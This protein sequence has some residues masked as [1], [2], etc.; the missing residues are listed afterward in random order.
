MD[1]KLS[2]ILSDY[3][4][5][6]DLGEE[7]GLYA[8]FYKAK[9]GNYSFLLPNTKGRKKA[10]IKHD[11]H[12]LITE[13]E[14][15]FKGELEIGGWEVASGC[16]DYYGIWMLNLIGM[17]TGI[18]LIP[19]RTYQA[20]IRGI[21]NKNLYHLDINE[22]EYRNMR[23]EDITSMLDFDAERTGKKN[24]KNNVLF[25]IW[26]IISVIVTVLIP[27]YYIISMMV[28]LI[29]NGKRVKLIE[30]LN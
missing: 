24:L 4:E 12:H 28:L 16:A 7:G 17:A 19:R 9:I 20:F 5:E 22:S 23:L 21:D 2:A 11:I 8:D 14:V 3:F 13:Y 29:K 1:D 30:R 15:D 6:K 10:L 27:P 18:F 25:I 26:S